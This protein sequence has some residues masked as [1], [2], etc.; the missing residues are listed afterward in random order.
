MT[1]P[2][3]VDFGG[4]S[5]EITRAITLA[6]TTLTDTI[7]VTRLAISG[8]G[9]AYYT[10]KQVSYPHMIP[11][12]TS[13]D[14]MVTYTPP[15]AG[16]TPLATLAVTSSAGKTV[17]IRLRATAGSSGI[18]G[19][20]IALGGGDLSGVTP[21]PFTS[22]TTIRYRSTGEREHITIDVLNLLGQRM[23]VVSERIESAGEH[24]ATFDGAALPTGSYLCRMVI[25][26]PSGSRTIT[27]PIL[28]VR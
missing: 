1:A 21:N 14:V 23:A 11:G 2:D 4:G 13:W 10:L 16:S 5:G 15:V 9:A 25:E 17:N 26:G 24:S 12:G 8:A 22:T 7:S 28:L 3:T 27:R 18:E 19:D 20:T 6:N